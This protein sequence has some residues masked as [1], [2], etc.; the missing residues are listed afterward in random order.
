MATYV[1]PRPDQSAQ[2]D[3]E[4]N[5]KGPLLGLILAITVLAA[6]A[7]FLVGVIAFM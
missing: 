1:P 7:A 2:H 3:P 6:V 4:G 5:D